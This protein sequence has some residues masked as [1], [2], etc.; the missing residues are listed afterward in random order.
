[1]L[2]D[3]LLSL[4][5]T[6]HIE[7][8][9][10]NRDMIHDLRVQLGDKLKERCAFGFDATNNLVLYPSVYIVIVTGKR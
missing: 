10:R 3:V 8:N 1:M 6:L 7:V 5:H 4:S 2:Y 9:V